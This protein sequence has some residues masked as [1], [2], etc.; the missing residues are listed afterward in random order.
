MA[1]ASTFHCDGRVA[2]RIREAAA[3]GTLSHAIILSGQ[4]DLLAAAR[5]TAAAMQ[6]ESTARPCLSCGACSK[7]E[8]GIHP[9]VIVVEDT[10]HKNISIDTLRAMRADAYIIPNEGARK[11]YIFPDCEKLDPKAQNVLLKVVEEGPPHAAFLFCAENSAQLLQ[12]IR[13]RA[14][15]L[16]LG[17][18]SRASEV[19]EGAER[20]AFLLCEKKRS[21]ITSFFTELE[22]SKISREDLRS[23]LSETRDLLSAALAAGYGVPAAFPAASRLSREMSRQRLTACIGILER[24]I[25]D[26]SFQVGVGHL[27]GALAAELMA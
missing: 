2:L 17:G 27:T 6:C 18:D 19:S 14:V 13:S 8:R 26:C 21:H 15:E 7:V 12:T 1:Q 25:R 11:V 22:N 16:K 20:L 23:L 24:F 3:N 4:G 9:D 10:E 5:Y